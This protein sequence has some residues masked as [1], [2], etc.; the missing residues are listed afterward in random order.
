MEEIKVTELGESFEGTP[1]P[2]IGLGLA[3]AG[4]AGGAACAGGAGGLGC[5]GGCVGLGCGAGCV[6]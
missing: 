2:R 1:T 6:S 3:C 5:G 4:I